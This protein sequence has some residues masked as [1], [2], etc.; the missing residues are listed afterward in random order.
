ME[1]NAEKTRLMRNSEESIRS[2]T[3][4]ANGDNETIQIPWY[5]HQPRWIQ[6][7]S[8]CEN[9]I[10]NSRDGR[11]ETDLKRQKSLKNKLRLLHV[12][13]LSVLLY[14][15]ESCTNSKTQKMQK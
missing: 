6:A 8:E 2:I 11:V 5:N 13:V 1:I 12:L 9:Y 10:N 3:V 15:C 4:E 14:V 7:I